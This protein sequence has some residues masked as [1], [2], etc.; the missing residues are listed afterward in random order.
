M[1]TEKPSQHEHKKKIKAVFD[2]LIA[3]LEAVGDP[4]KRGIPPPKGFLDMLEKKGTPINTP[5]GQAALRGFYQNLKDDKSVNNLLYKMWRVF[6][7]CY[8]KRDTLEKSISELELYEVKHELPRT[9]FRWPR[10]RLLTVDDLRQ[11]CLILNHEWGYPSPKDRLKQ[12]TDESSESVTYAI[13]APFENFKRIEAHITADLQDQLLMI[14]KKLA[15]T[16]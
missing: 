15:Q 13:A 7:S 10:G 11:W 9:Y 5:K 16:Y 1:P 3:M 4:L 6:P 2:A 14:N 12:F 8:E